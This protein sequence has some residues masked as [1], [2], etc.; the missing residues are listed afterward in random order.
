MAKL[1]SENNSRGL[2]GTSP[3]AATG[4]A[5]TGTAVAV[6]HDDV[7]PEELSALVAVVVLATA[8]SDADP[9]RTDG[10]DPASGTYPRS[11]WGSPAR[12]FR[13]TPLHG[14]TGWRRS[15]SPS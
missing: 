8:R 10:A 13:R 14:R 4:T 1:M 7:S 6:V 5:A 9:N 12:M 3:R 11:P 15:A 2:S